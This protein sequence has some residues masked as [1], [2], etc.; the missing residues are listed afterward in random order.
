MGDKSIMI[1]AQPCSYVPIVPVPLVLQVGRRFDVPMMIREGKV[2][3]RPGIELGVVRDVIVQGLV[4][5]AEEAVRTG[6]PIMMAA[7][8]GEIGAKIAF[9][10][11]AV[12]RNNH[13]RC[14]WI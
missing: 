8:P 4:N 9:A 13:R 2:Q 6:F 12:L 1:E 7:V 3:L 5:G 14:G 11:A 10:V